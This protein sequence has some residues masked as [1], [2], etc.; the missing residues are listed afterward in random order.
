MTYISKMKRDGGQV[1]HH[2]LSAHRYSVFREIAA[3]PNLERHIAP[4]RQRLGERP[5][6]GQES[7][8]FKYTNLPQRPSPT[9]TLDALAGHLAHT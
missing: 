6:K 2:F 5:H 3:F 1:W 9:H 4:T 7:Q 8:T